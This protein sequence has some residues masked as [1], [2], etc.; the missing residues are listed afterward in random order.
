MSNT[1]RIFY[2]ILNVLGFK[3][4]YDFIIL[5]VF[6]FG[7]SLIHIYRVFPAHENILILNQIYFIFYTSS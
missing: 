3:S 5:S 2:L 1:N 4:Y 7:P 6:L